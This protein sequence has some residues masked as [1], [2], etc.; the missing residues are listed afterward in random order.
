MIFQTK[1]SR[2]SQLLIIL[3]VVL[4]SVGVT[5]A[6]DKPKYEI[7]FSSLAPEGTT[8]MN[9]FHE[10][11]DE[12]RAATNGQVGFK[13][14]PGGVQG[15][16]PDVL[17]KMRFGQLHAGGFTGNGLGTVLSSMRILEVP[18]LFESKAEVDFIL[19]EYTDWFD[20]QF[21]EKGYVLLGWAEVGSVYIFSKEPITDFSEMR[22]VKMWS[23]QGDPLAA[24]LFGA[25][26]VTP[27][28]LSVPEVLTALQTGM[29]ESVYTSPLGLISLQWF[30]RIK[31]MN[32][33]PLTNSMGAV[34]MTK[35]QFDRIPEELQNILLE[36]S[37]KRL[38]ELTIA[39]RLDNTASIEEMKKIGI[40]MVDGPSDDLLAKYKVMGLGVRKGLIGELYSAEL[41]SNIE[42][43]LEKYRIGNAE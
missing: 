11:D 15:D 23:W 41:L 21:R 17:R 2:G 5:V 10:L 22:G 43:S 26:S 25:L 40:E 9:L 37:R 4:L 35:K 33:F 6:K 24:S 32:K 1:I 31:Y 28:P 13:M 14:Y 12:V 36:I 18:F 19:D 29:V 38:K 3:L 20:A 30:T 42:T 7:K 39:A 34:L 27:I 16:E 8:W